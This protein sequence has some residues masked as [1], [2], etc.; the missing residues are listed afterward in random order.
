MMCLCFNATAQLRGFRF[1]ASTKQKSKQQQQT[2]QDAHDHV[3]GHSVS[4]AFELRPSHAP[5][6]PILSSNRSSYSVGA[7]IGLYQQLS[8]VWLVWLL[9][10]LQC[11]RPFG[12]NDVFIC[13]SSGPR[14]MCYEGDVYHCCRRCIHSMPQILCG[15]CRK[16]ASS[17]LH[18]SAT[19]AFEKYTFNMHEAQ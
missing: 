19:I 6:S 13:D 1:H 15:D 3:C 18:L 11:Q 10:L 17:L 9:P 14:T 7:A 4:C 5:P 12:V 16:Q 2:T 8:R